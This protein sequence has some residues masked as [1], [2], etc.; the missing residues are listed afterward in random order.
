MNNRKEPWEAYPD[1]WPTKAKFFSWLQNNI[2]KEVY[3]G[4]QSQQD[5]LPSIE[6][7]S[8]IEGFIKIAM[9]V[10]PAINH[11]DS[12][13]QGFV[14]WLHK[15]EQ[16]DVMKEGYVGIT[17][18]IEVRFNQ[19]KYSCLN[20]DHAHKKSSGMKSAF[21]EGDI[22]C[23]VLFYGDYS[24]CLSLEQ[25]YRP[26]PNIGWNFA[27]GGNGGFPKHSLTGTNVSKMFYNLRTK[28]IKQ[29]GDF[30]W[31]GMLLDFSKFYFRTKPEN[32]CGAVLCRKDWLKG[33]YEDNLCWTTRS[34][35]LLKSSDK[36]KIYTIRGIS[37]TI[38]SLARHFDIKVNTVFVRLRDGWNL[39]KALCTPKKGTT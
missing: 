7:W 34:D 31:E 13:I 20:D 33:Y 17:Y 26:L 2:H 6:D 29:F 39:E 5:N 27:V 23:D 16:K 14:Y 36:S 32:V 25:H 22:L 8:D 4:I 10:K 28:S 3:C 15:E 11:A 38:T 1:V 9:F 12:G 30:Y 18:D 19:H 37:G 21:I 35:M 24:E